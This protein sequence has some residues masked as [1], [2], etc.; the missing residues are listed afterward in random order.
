MIWVIVFILIISG[1]V[2]A[3]ISPVLGVIIAGTGVLTAAS[4]LLRGKK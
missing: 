4:I 1:N 2:A 3:L